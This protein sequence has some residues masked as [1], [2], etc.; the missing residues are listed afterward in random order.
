M[1]RGGTAP[2][3]GTTATGRPR[4]TA[5]TRRGTP[6][7]AFA[8]AGRVFCRVHDPDRAAEVRAACARGGAKA[9]KLR[10]LEGR[11]RKLDTPAA[12]VGFVSGVIYDVVEHRVE[13]DV[14]RTALY[15]C[16]IQ[17]QLLEATDLAARLAAV[18]AQLAARRT[19]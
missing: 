2:P 17:R 3:S 6:C 12:L 5:T 1:G 16:S 11:R 18:E 14:A 4:C 7:E 9:S 8:P 10:A 19:G 15:G 13:V